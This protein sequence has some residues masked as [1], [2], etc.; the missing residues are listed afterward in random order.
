MA[1][2]MYR[3]L[4]SWIICVVITVGVSL[5]TKPKPASELVDL[6]YGAT[7]IPS[8]SDLKLTQRPI[9][10]VAIALVVFLALNI[11]FR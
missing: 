6:V 2:N 10:W 3:A 7:E 8:E 4:W 11:T 1:E 9:F 5:M